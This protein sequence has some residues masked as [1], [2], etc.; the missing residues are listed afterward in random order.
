MLQKIHGN[1][2]TSIA[3]TALSLAAL[4][5]FAAAPGCDR[6]TAVEPEH[7]QKPAG[8]LV[9]RSDCKGSTELAASGT[10]AIR[11]CIEYELA[12]G[13]TLLL[14]HINAAFNCCPGDITADISFR[15]DTITIVERE[16]ESGCRCLCLYDLDYRFENIAPGI[17]TILIVEPYVTDADEPLR[18]TIDLSVSPSGS[19]CVDR[20]SY[21]WS[22]GGGAAPVGAL[23]SRT[24]CNSATHPAGEE[25][26]PAD[27]SCA[28]WTYGPDG[29]L[30][31]EHVNAAFNCCPGDITA[32]ISFRNDTITIVERE[33]Q[34][35]CDCSCLYNLKFEIRNLEPRAYTIRFV[36]PYVQSDDERLE[37]TADLAALPMGIA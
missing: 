24:E 14:R 5:L 12:G 20:A 15:N 18:S 16:S 4:A 2:Y 28:A 10:A 1:R 26:A 30:S 36:E 17:Y 23:V 35:I 7:H 34:S 19:F 21:P 25:P 29:V 32:D 3:V 13:D 9:S 33:E 8:A 22:T 11:D 27:L 6:E 37:F 31:L